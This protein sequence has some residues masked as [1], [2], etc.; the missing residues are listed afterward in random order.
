M[1]MILSR[2]FAFAKLSAGK[3]KFSGSL[4]CAQSMRGRDVMRN[5]NTSF[6]KNAICRFGNEASQVLRAFIDPATCLPRL[7]QSIVRTIQLYLLPAGY[8]HQRQMSLFGT[9]ADKATPTASIDGVLSLISGE[10]LERENGI[11]RWDYLA[12][13]TVS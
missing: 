4:F 1:P 8:R 5:F 10:T 13:Q 6:V 3:I 11:S 12:G 2:H 9:F 7:I